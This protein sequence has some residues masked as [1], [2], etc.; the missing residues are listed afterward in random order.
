[1]LTG[2]GSL[3]S[4]VGSYLSSQSTAAASELLAAGDVSAA[5]DYTK[6]ANIATQNVGIEGMSTAIQ[7]AQLNRKI[8]KTVSGQQAATGAANVGGG[9]AGDL[10]R[11]SFSQGALAQT[12]VTTQGNIQKNAF[13]EQATAYQAMAGSANAAAAAAV[14]QANAQKTN[15]LFGLGG[16]ILS[17]IGGLFGL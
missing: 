11:E 9:S 1:M 5:G 14:Q 10:L 13:E 6:A 15:G 12:L 3:V 17:F 7:Q 2:L 4:G 16:G 8:Y